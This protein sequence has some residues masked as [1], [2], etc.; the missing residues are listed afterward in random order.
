MDI[1]DATAPLMR[2]L[3]DD[4]PAPVTVERPDA[5]SR[6]LLA[7]D[8][9][10]KRIPR[11]LADLGLGAE[12]RERHIAWDIGALAV[13]R[14]LSARLDATL[15]SQ[16]YSRLVIDCNRDPSVADSIAA[17][18]ETTPIPGNEA[19]APEDAEARVVEILRP[20]Q[21]AI[22]AAL[23]ARDRAGRV[24][25]LVAVHSFTPVYKGVARPWRLGI[26][27]NRDK[28]LAHAMIARARQAGDLC[29]GDNQPYHIS[30]ETDYTIPVH[31]ELRGIAHVE[32]EIRQDLIADAGGQGEWAARLETY[33]TGALA[34]IEAAGVWP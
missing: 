2:L 30:D 11:A 20:Y 24:S 27:Y 18:S 9:A 3:A 28:R 25:V 7:C 17:V 32:I 23:D 12:D 1:M 31:G 10:G 22:G 15:I 6:F 13:A 34:D 16:T 4:E 21:T 19:L 33:L 29:V 14:D 5:P 26:L 8:H